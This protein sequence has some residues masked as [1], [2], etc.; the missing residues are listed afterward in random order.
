M[1]DAEKDVALHVEG[2]E[3][4]SADAAPKIET[5]VD[6]S[7]LDTAAAK[8]DP[9]GASATTAE[10]IAV[11]E[12]APIQV[13]L[14]LSF[15]TSRRD[16]SLTLHR[17]FEPRQLEAASAAETNTETPAAVPVVAATA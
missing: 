7:K 16:L 11:V 8:S 14:L 1:T 15:C 9:V 10:P 4:T 3:T 6:E 12:T 17:S 5:A 2:G 13:R